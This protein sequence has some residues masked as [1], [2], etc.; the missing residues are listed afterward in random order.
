MRGRLAVLLREGW[1]VQQPYL[2]WS[3]YVISCAV[4]ITVFQHIVVDDFCRPIVLCPKLGLDDGNSDFEAT[5]VLAT[6]M[7]SQLNTEAEQQPENALVGSQRVSQENGPMNSTPNTAR[8][9]GAQSTPGSAQRSGNRS[10]H[11]VVWSDLSGT[12]SCNQH[13]DPGSRLNRRIC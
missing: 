10:D 3:C 12:F 5:L 8:Q 13:C 4:Y 9:R 6:M 2:A 11:T 7:S 1:K